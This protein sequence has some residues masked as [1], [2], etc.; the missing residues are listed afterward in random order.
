ME[1]E[2]PPNYDFA[3]RLQSFLDLMLAAEMFGTYQDQA[4]F[5]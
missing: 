1:L 2:S 5:R 3:E 4:P